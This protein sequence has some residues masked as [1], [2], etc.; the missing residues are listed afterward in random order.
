MSRARAQS[1][2]RRTMRT[3]YGASNPVP[4]STKNQGKRLQAIRIWPAKKKGRK[5]NRRKWLEKAPIHIGVI[6]F[7]YHETGFTPKN[8]ED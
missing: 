3:M 2:K 6:K 7:I 5:T 1:S 4:N 8:K